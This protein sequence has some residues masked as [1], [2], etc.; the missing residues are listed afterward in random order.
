MLPKELSDWENQN[1]KEFEVKEEMMDMTEEME[2][3]RDKRVMT[4]EAEK[5]EGSN[6]VI[7]KLTEIG[8]GSR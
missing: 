4:R 6:A 1:T 8:D 3:W 5:R 7:R 2:L